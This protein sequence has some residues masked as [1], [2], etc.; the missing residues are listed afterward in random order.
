MQP[1]AAIRPL[2]RFEDMKATAAA[3]GLNFCITQ[4]KEIPCVG[5][6]FLV[7]S[8]CLECVVG[9][10]RKRPRVAEVG[11]TKD[12]HSPVERLGF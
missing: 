7:F 4:L 5:D 2:S 11:K 3:S 1:A 10:C 8:T 12:V 6:I 9:D